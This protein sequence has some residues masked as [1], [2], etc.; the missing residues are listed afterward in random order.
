MTRV[1]NKILVILHDLTA[2]IS[3]NKQICW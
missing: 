2:N 3:T 1:D